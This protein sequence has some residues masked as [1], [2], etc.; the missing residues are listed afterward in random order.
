MYCRSTVQGTCMSARDIC[1]HGKINFRVGY[2]RAQGEFTLPPNGIHVPIH[3]KWI[4]LR[5]GHMHTRN[6]YMTAR[7]I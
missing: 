5:K 1:I 6:E 7:Y 2:M 4:Y 3:Y